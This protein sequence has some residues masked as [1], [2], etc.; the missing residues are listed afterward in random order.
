M[1][2]LYFLWFPIPILRAWYS[3]MLYRYM[4]PLQN[5][6]CFTIGAFKL[7]NETPKNFWSVL[8]YN[9]YMSDE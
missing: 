6:L 3:H 5:S 8:F 7:V 4:K 2:M 9:H 1:G